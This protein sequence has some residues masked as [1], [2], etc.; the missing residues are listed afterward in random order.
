MSRIIK[1]NIHELLKYPEGRRVIVPVTVD[2]PQLQLNNDQIAAN[3]VA[4][5]E[6]A[7]PPYPDDSLIFVEITL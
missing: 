1:L 5:L 7:E 2:W 4:R 6:G 3:A